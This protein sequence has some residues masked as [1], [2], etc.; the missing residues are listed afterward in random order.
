MT[1]I[2]NTVTSFSNPISLTRDEVNVL[3]DIHKERFYNT[4]STNWGY[5]GDLSR[6]IEILD[7]LKG[8]LAGEEGQTEIPYTPNAGMAYYERQ[9]AIDRL[10]AYVVK[11]S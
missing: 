8:S 4:G 9:L 1:T 7:D 11:E 6:V 2:Y 5:V 10:L 3:L